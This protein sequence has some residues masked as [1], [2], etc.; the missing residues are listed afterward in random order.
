MVNCFTFDYAGTAGDSLSQLRGMA[1][2]TKD[3]D[4]DK[5][6]DHCASARQA[7]GAWWY[8]SSAFSNLNGLYHPGYLNVVF[9]YHWKKRFDSLKRTEMKI[10]PVKA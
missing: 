4:N 8:Y 6:F 7:H 3:R 5:L 10:R 1:F 2:L 9:W